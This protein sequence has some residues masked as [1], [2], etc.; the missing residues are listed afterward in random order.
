MK[1]FCC[2]LIRGEVYLRKLSTATPNPNALLPVGNVTEFSVA[3][4]LVEI[5]QAN[6]QSLGGTACKVSFVDSATLNLTMGCI[7]SRNLALAILGDGSF[8]NVVA[9]TVTGETHRVNAVDELVLFDFIPDLTAP[10]VVT[11]VGGATTYVEGTDYQLTA[12]GIKILEGTTITLAA[13][14]EVD[15]EY[16][17]NTAIN[18]LT[19]SQSDYEVVLA[20]IN[21]ADGQE[22]PVTF[23]AFKVKFNPT[24][25]LSLIG[26]DLATISV[27]GEIL[28]DE[29]KL[30][31]SK[32]YN[33][34]MGE[35]A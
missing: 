7:K 8:E 35:L 17:A 3:H 12:H 22:T 2:Q 15:Y 18:A 34:Q 24:E 31:G 6:Y 23:K 13:D 30:T 28:R 29:T 19:Q 26:D 20:G 33:F 27:V 16:G 5:E 9:G 32:F 4:E 25:E 11:N 14:I 21:A 10:V 1:D